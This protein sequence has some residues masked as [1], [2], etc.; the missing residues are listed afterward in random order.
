MSDEK[1]SQAGD[2]SEEP[3]HRGR[4]QAQGGGTEKS[5]P[6][7]QATPP[8][9]S[10]MLVKCDRLEGRLGTKEKRDREEAM[11]RLRRFIANAAVGGGVEA[12]VSKS[13]LKSGSKDV[14]IDLE[15]IK[16]RACVPDPED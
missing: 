8:T 5:E 1:Q 13:F 7:A 11:A 2:E 4:V 15:V 3:R 16:G 6:W 10:E 9:K 12:P 14:R